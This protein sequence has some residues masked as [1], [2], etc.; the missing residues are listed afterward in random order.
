M[1]VE[2]LNSVTCCSYVSVYIYLVLSMYV[3]YWSAERQVLCRWW[4]EIQVG[5]LAMVSFAQTEWVDSLR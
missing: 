3:F 1:L 5:E 2:N 4:C